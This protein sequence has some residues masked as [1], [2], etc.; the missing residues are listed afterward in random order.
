LIHSACSVVYYF[1][2]PKE[3]CDEV[4]QFQ[5]I[6]GYG[7]GGKIVNDPSANKEKSGF[8]ILL[9]FTVFLFL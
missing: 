5:E 4:T 1:A 9:V 8:F 7:R 6:I 3:H 2:Q